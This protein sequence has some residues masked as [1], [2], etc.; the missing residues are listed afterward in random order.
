MKKEKEEL[1]EGL[2]TLTPRFF[3]NPAATGKGFS[4]LN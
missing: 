4:I 2:N 3:L 1:I